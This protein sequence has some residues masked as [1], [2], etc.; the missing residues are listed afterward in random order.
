M[1]ALH[2]LPFSADIRQRSTECITK[3]KSYNALFQPM[4]AITGKA[5]RETNNSRITFDANI[6]M[7]A[8]P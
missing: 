1:K 5:S 2:P 3:A 8:I 6:P 4:S 7:T